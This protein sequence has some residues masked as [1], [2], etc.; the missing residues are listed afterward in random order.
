MPPIV[1]NIGKLGIS[2]N[3]DN[4]LGLSDT[5]FLSLSH[6]LKSVN[7]NFNRSAAFTF[8]SIPY[9]YWT[10]NSYGTLS[11]FNTQFHYN[12]IVPNSAVAVGK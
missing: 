6:T 9:G 11:K 10:L 12:I 7:T 3:V 1:I 8:H 2:F 5:L 4:P